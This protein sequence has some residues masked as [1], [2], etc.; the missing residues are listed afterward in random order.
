LV[1]WLGISSALVVLGIMTQLGSSVKIAYAAG[2]RY[3]APGGN[4]SGNN[5]ANNANPCATIQHAVDVADPDD[6]IKIATGVYTSVTMPEVVYIS[7]SLT[8]QGGYLPAFTEPP[9]PVANPT[10]LDAQGQGGVLNITGN[11]SVTIAGLRLTG[12]GDGGS[13]GSGVSVF[14]ATVTLSNNDI[15]SNSAS[16]AGGVF[17]DHSRATLIN[18]SILSNTAEVDGGGLF[19]LD[20]EATFS[21][22][23]I[24]NNSA[25]HTGGGVYLYEGSATFENNLITGNSSG[26]AGGG[27][28]TRHN[29]LSFT[30]N[31]VTGNESGDAGG[32]GL[33][34][35]NNNPL[36]STS[37]SLVTLSQNLISNNKATYG[38]GLFLTPGQGVIR[39]NTI[40]DNQAASGGGGLLLAFDKSLVANNL[41]S[42][43]LVTGDSSHGDFFGGGGLTLVGSQAT[44][45]NNTIISN[46][47]LGIGGGGVFMDRESQSTLTNNW[48]V[49]NQ[50]NI[51]GSGLYMGGS[52]AHLLHNTFSSNKGEVSGIYLTEASGPGIIYSNVFLTNTIIANHYLGLEVSGGNT[53]TLQS[54]LWYNNSANWSGSGTITANNNYTGDPAF[55]NSTGG[56]YHLDPA[57]AAIDKGIAVGVTTDIDGETRDSLPDLGADEGVKAPVLLISVKAPLGVAAG[58]Q[59]TYTLTV[60]NSGTAIATN[61][62]ITDTLP[63][64]THYVTG[65]TKIGNV[66][67]W[68]VPAL[69]ANGG[70]I[71]KSFI[72]TATQTITNT[73]YGVR[74]DGGYQAQG[75]TPVVTVIENEEEEQDKLYLPLII[76]S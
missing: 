72:V 44:L 13:F 53:A 71:K 64:G 2:P 10:T 6:I 34:I 61:L 60:T 21:N 63:S 3:V 66:V 36:T 75:L 24:G 38:G 17:L 31:V 69:A 65:G 30:K 58:S 45:S 39:Q 40:I 5:C 57:S 51:A 20:S 59:I 28:H 22:N 18:N 37:Y 8:L 14:T 73:N 25:G 4:D 41:I 42:N 11:I 32:G 46:S 43:N 70:V 35:G 55:L 19:L 74:A 62:V 7:K 47:A 48:V 1:F 23:Q 76:K 12:A 50:T 56:D 68:T 27:L 52:S 16:L 9:E 33:Y 15:F 29:N 54:T 26:V 67:S 49:N